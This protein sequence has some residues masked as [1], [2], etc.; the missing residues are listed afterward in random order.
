[1]TLTV[2]SHDVALISNPV[3]MVYSD[4]SVLYYTFRLSKNVFP[5]GRI[6]NSFPTLLY[7]G[8]TL[9]PPLSNLLFFCPPLKIHFPPTHRKNDRSLM[10]SQQSLPGESICVRLQRCC[11]LDLVIAMQSISGNKIKTYHLSVVSR[12]CLINRICGTLT[13]SQFILFQG[14]L[15]SQKSFKTWIRG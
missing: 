3:N 7:F 11:S 10:T 5:P 6:R 9:F 14:Y 15:K 13:L 12:N 1:M 8:Q 2:V 4:H